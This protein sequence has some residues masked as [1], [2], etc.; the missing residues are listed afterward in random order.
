[1]T[2]RETLHSKVKIQKMHPD[3]CSASR[4]SKQKTDDCINTRSRI[5]PEQLIS[6]VTTAWLKEA[7]PFHSTQHTTI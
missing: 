7:G 1:M 6:T 3:V 5:N 4:D 2:R